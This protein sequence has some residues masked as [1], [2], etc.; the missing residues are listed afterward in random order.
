MGARQGIALPPLPHGNGSWAIIHTATGQCALELMR[1]DAR[2]AALMNAAAFHA[3]PI[4]Q[5]LSSIN[6]KGAQCL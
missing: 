2:R 1:G 5:Y 4:G 6:G 3:V